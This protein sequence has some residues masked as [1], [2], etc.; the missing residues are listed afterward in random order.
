MA[1]GYKVYRASNSELFGLNQTERMSGPYQKHPFIRSDWKSVDKFRDAQGYVPTIR[2]NPAGDLIVDERVAHNGS[3]FASPFFPG[4]GEIQDKSYY[5]YLGADAQLTQTHVVTVQFDDSDWNSV[6]AAAQNDPLIDNLLAQEDAGGP[7]AGIPY[8]AKYFYLSPTADPDGNGGLLTTD[9]R[10]AGAS[11]NTRPL[12]NQQSFG[13][14]SP[15]LSHK[16]SYRHYDPAME[17]TTYNITINSIYNT[18]LDTDPDYE[19]AISNVPETLLPNYYHLEIAIHNIGQGTP[20]PAYGN[21]FSVASTPEANL[22][23]AEYRAL[24]EGN[25]PNTNV[26]ETQT[27]SQG[28]LQFYANNVD[29]LTSNEVSIDLWN[30]QFQNVAVMSADIGSD[31]LQTFNNIPRDNRGTLDSTSDDLLAIESYPFYNHITIP[32]E[33]QWSAAGVQGSVIEALKSSILGIEWVENFLTCLELLILD[34]YSLKP[35]Q[36][37]FAGK[38]LA[39]FTIY[40]H[41]DGNRLIAESAN[42]DLVLKIEAVLDDLLR[43]PGYPVYDQLYK[44]LMLGGSAQNQ[45]TYL[46]NGFAGLNPSVS[47]IKDPGT[48]DAFAQNLFDWFNFS[49]T[50]IN[51]TNALSVIASFRNGMQNEFQ[52][53]HRADENSSESIHAS[54]PIMY[55]IEKRVVP[56]GQTQADLNQPPIQR[57]FFGR[58]ISGANR[59]V[60][61]FDTQIKYGVRY[62]YDLK[63]IRM[64]VGESYYYHSVYA[65]TNSSSVGQGRAIGNALGFYAPEIS[66]STTSEIYQRVNDDLLNFSYLPEEEETGF[67]ADYHLGYYIYRTSPTLGDSYLDINNVLGMPPTPAGSPLPSSGLNDIGDAQTLAPSRPP[68]AAVADLQILKIEIKG[69][70][71][72]DGNPS[73]GAMPVSEDDDDL[74]IDEEALGPDPIEDPMDLAPGALQAEQE[75][76]GVDPDLI[77]RS[78]E[79]TSETEIIDQNLSTFVVDELGI[80]T[81]TMV[82]QGNQATVGQ[83][84]GPSG[85]GTTII[86]PGGAVTVPGS[87]GVDTLGPAGGMPPA[88]A[89]NIAGNQTQIQQQQGFDQTVVNNLI[90]SGLIRE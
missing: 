2:T 9:P 21:M 13:P 64:I 89:N 5:Y 14:F 18:F 36:L 33:N 84:Y 70:L 20:E 51:I 37:K 86:L 11:A 67:A 65:S 68:A 72:F 54:E 30:N 10:M 63:Q 57:L 52:N 60:S 80:E 8:Y 44:L 56:V 87:T 7:W 43:G 41:T 23:Q 49:L 79:S 12:M 1:S 55:M 71:G 66:Y 16:F 27:N 42:I 47:F 4:S 88:G 24:L 35:T 28:F 62:Q 3:S 77:S 32:Y 48:L 53:I 74:I 31:V 69:G 75:G 6:N 83:T 90:D 81:E 85:R 29:V 15:I 17:D 58:D 82:N 76:E 78:S 59:G 22:S 26:L 25:L 34:Q 50:P 39:P 46:W 45:V 19:T 38:T 61:Y 73:G 40:D